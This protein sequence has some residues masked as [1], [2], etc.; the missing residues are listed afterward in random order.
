MT[1]NVHQN[2]FTTTKQYLYLLQNSHCNSIR[3]KVRLNWKTKIRKTSQL[4]QIIPYFEQWFSTGNTWLKNILMINSES[5]MNF[6][7]E[8]VV[9]SF[10]NWIFHGENY[11]FVVFPANCAAREKIFLEYCCF[12]RQNSTRWNPRSTLHRLA[13]F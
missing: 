7:L 1:E 3:T 12:I 4:L 13:A 11:A 8:N 5:K 6:S 2:N 9:K 10:S